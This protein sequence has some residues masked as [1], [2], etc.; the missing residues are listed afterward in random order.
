MEVQEMTLCFFSQTILKLYRSKNAM[1]AMPD[2]V[3]R[4][5]NTNLKELS[6]CST[7]EGGK[8]RCSDKWISLVRLHIPLVICQVVEEKLPPVDNCS[9]HLQPDLQS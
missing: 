2:T 4:S 8:L 7:I 6:S 1:H 5:V 3:Q 9:D